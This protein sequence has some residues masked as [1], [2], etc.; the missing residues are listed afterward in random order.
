MKF[1]NR[2]HTK[3]ERDVWTSRRAKVKWESWKW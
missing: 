2:E 1:S 3:N